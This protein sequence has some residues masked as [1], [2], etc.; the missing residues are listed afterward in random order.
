MSTTELSTTKITPLSNKAVLEKKP[1]SYQT[2]LLGAG[3]LIIYIHDECVCE[4]KGLKR[5]NFNRLEFIR[6]FDIRSTF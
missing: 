2:L 6:D 1:I 3:T 4:S 5:V